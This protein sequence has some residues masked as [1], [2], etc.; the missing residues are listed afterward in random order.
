MLVFVPWALPLKHACACELPTSPRVAA[1]LPNCAGTLAAQLGIPR[2]AVARNAS[3]YGSD[4]DTLSSRDWS[5]GACGR[6]PRL[7]CVQGLH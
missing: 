5:D 3:Y 7:A 4:A 6:S 2:A 1:L